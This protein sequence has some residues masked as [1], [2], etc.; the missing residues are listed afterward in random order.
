MQDQICLVLSLIMI[1]NHGHSVLTDG[2]ADAV[3]PPNKT[4]Q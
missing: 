2:V 3:N 4:V 1:A